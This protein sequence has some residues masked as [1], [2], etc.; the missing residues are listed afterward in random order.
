MRGVVSR[1]LL[2][3]LPLLGLAAYTDYASAKRKMDLIEGDRLA[4][5]TRVELTSAELNAWAAREAAGIAGVRQP[6]LQL[7]SGVATGEALIDFNQLRSARTGT[8]EALTAR[9]LEGERPVKVS[10]RIRSSGGTAT[11]DVERVEVS[12]LVLDGRMLDFAIRHFLLSNYPNAAIG[13]PFELGHRI[14][15]LDVQPQGVGVVIGR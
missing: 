3:L 1:F 8:L 11:V 7:G 14:E 2:V 6:R 4:R 9:L 10:A 5:G 15:R 13:R 12:G